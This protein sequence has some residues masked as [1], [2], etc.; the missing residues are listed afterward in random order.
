MLKKNR[1]LLA[2]ASLFVVVVVVSTAM[3]S[4]RDTG[5]VAQPDVDGAVTLALVADHVDGGST[6][7]AASAAPSPA[8]GTFRA[9]GPKAYELS[10][11]GS[12][13]PP[14]DARAYVQQLLPRSEA[15]DGTASYE[16][17]L[18]VLECRTFTSDRVDQL[19]QSA[20][21]V[22][23]EKAFLERSERLLRE[24]GALVL[25]RDLYPGNWLEK[26]A[27]QGSVEGQLGYARSPKD[28]LGT[29]ADILAD[30]ERAVAWKHTAGQY[31]ETLARSGIIDAV[32]ELAR[33]YEHGGIVPRDPVAAYAYNLALQQVNP[34]YVS[35]LVMQSLDAELSADQRAR[36]RLLANTL[37]G[38]CCVP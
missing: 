20:A 11:Q 6:V 17:Y 3:L 15:G 28:V 32:A 23:A 5:S 31:L 8:P 29:Y 34:N 18:T 21:L 35:P 27:L 9:V 10:R 36:A 25:D 30:P 19:A 16:I 14:G 22:G 2:A 7:G 24:C 37:H 26:A 4:A 1:T 33:D 12:H 38:A 13:R